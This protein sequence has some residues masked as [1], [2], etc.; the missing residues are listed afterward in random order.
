MEGARGRSGTAAFNQGA[1]S[2]QRLR[3]STHQAHAGVR[4]GGGGSCWCGGGVVGPRR[5]GYGAL[6]RGAARERDEAVVR[7][8]GR[9]VLPL[10]CTHGGGGE[11]WARWA[12]AGTRGAGVG[13]GRLRATKV[14]ARAAGQASGST[15]GPALP[16]PPAHPNPLTAVR[17]A[18]ARP[19]AAGCHDGKECNQLVDGVLLACSRVQRCGCCCFAVK[20]RLLA[21]LCCPHSAR[22]SGERTGARAP[23]A[24]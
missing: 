21:L 2:R 23:R 3:G 18:A 7:V 17:R 13:G 14:R 15:L 5:R 1:G 22:L 12:R 6:L 19:V 10:V 4:V 16:S 8:D 11:G 9:Q 20:A 24:L